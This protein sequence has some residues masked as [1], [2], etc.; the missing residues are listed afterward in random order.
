MDEAEYPG[1]RVSLETVLAEKLETLISRNITNTRMRDFYDMYILLKLYGDTLNASTMKDALSATAKKRGTDKY[2]KNA[3]NIIEEVNND[4]IMNKLWK[5]YQRKFSYA[6]DISW[7]M[8]MDSV[9]S[10]YEMCK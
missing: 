10:L 4:S 1:I 7:D 8:A 2:L 6:K 9:K 3:K 5:A